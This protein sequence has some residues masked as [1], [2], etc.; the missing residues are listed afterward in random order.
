MGTN[1]TLGVDAGA[2]ATAEAEVA[3]GLEVGWALADRAPADGVALDGTAVPDDELAP[4]AD[5]ASPMPRPTIKMPAILVVR[6][7]CRGVVIVSPYRFRYVSYFSLQTARVI[8][9]SR[10]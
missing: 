8:G 10:D 3:T 2:M 1:V 5:S 7:K 4:Q 6:M 9:Q